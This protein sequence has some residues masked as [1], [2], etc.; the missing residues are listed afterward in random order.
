MTFNLDVWNGMTD[1]Q[2]MRDHVRV[3]EERDALS[4]ENE[5]LRARLA[6]A[7]QVIGAASEHMTRHDY[8]EAHWMLD[9]YSNTSLCPHGLY[10]WNCRDCTPMSASVQP[11]VGQDERDALKAVGRCWFCG[12][13]PNECPRAS[14]ECRA[15]D[16]GTES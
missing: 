15:A 10:P 11:S 8:T 7:E 5:S 4:A 6:E 1:S 13:D 3:I 16:N 9:A 2:R 14:G 12:S